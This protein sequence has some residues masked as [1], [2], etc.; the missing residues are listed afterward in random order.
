MNNTTI[1]KFK[2][3]KENQQDDLYFI[4]YTSYSSNI[5]HGGIYVYLN[6]EVYVNLISNLIFDYDEYHIIET[7]K[8]D[9]YLGTF[10]KFIIKYFS[11]N[12]PT[13]YRFRIP[14]EKEVKN[15]NGYDTND[16]S[17]QFPENNDITA[18]ITPEEIKDIGNLYDINE[19]IKYLSMIKD[20][21]LHVE[22][23]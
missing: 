19:V 4:K 5:I 8:F 18:P 20:D 12:A 15:N 22:K 14:K 11:D 10:I 16:I 2:E 21:V 7:I 6:N 3:N 23:K 17:D 1:N 9:D 13:L